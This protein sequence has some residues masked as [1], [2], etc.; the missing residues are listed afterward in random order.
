MLRVVVELD[1]SSRHWPFQ[2]LSVFQT[3]S[4]CPSSYMN[5]S[6]A[7]V[8]ASVASAAPQSFDIG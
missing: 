1:G 3:Y 6:D 8:L 7:D 4:Y 2:A 5:G